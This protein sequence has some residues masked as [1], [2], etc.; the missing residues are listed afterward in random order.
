MLNQLKLRAGPVV[1]SLHENDVNRKLLVSCAKTIGL[2]S[3]VVWKEVRP[4]PGEETNGI[5]KFTVPENTDPGLPHTNP[6]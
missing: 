4:L 2:L 1:E 3:I 6:L 5:G